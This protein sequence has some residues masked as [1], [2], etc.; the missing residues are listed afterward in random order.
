MLPAADVDGSVDFYPVE[1]KQ[2][3]I[4]IEG[5][6]IGNVQINHLA[7]GRIETKIVNGV[8]GGEERTRGAALGHVEIAPKLGR[9]GEELGFRDGI[10]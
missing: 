4:N 3:E 7:S 9:C 10:V 1:R 8:A 6:L 5:V 2:V